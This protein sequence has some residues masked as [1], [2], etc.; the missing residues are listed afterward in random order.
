MN[1]NELYHFIFETYAGIGI[2]IAIGLVISLLA[3]VILEKR[4][5][6]VFRDR[7]EDEE[8]EWDLFDDDEE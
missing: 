7:P 8:D 4:T 5:R 2:L 3:S 6:A 1:I